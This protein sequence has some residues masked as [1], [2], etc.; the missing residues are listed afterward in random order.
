MQSQLPLV[1][2]IVTT[3]NEE[4][5]IKRFL[6]SVKNQTY[7]NLEVI[8]VDNNSQDKTKEI[9]WKYTNHVFN[10]GPERSSQRN[11]GV[12]KSRGKYLLILDADMELGSS[13]VED[14]LRTAKQ[15]NYKLLVIPEKTVGRG[16]IAKIR[17]FE[18]EMYMGDLSVEVARFFDKKV[19]EEYGGYDL[20]LTG[21]EDY[22]LPYR[23]SKK[24]KIGRA[25]EY[26]LHH[27]AD[28]TL[29]KLLAKKYYYAFRGAK[30]ARK[31]PELVKTQG[32]LLFRKAYFRNWKQFLR[33]PFL[34]ISFLAIRILET[35]WAVAGFINAVGFVNFMKT[36]FS[37][38]K[39]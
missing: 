2:V 29:P 35:I 26:I 30:Y 9:A 15:G 18:R 10:Y 16:F 24:Y 38:L 28:L 39:S 1:S 37:T 17:N 34:G 19:F 6:E 27:E 32:N 11:F 36:A 5:N 8:V 23:I 4:R 25:S 22:D 13:V 3:K 20:N 14:C 21:P 7:K 31:H 33:H 12:S